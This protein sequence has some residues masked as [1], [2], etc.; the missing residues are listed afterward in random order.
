M[1]Q[2]LPICFQ[3]Y[4]YRHALQISLWEN[5]CPFFAQCKV[6]ETIIT[7]AHCMVADQVTQLSDIP[8]I[9]ST[10]DYVLVTTVLIAAKI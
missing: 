7:W 5:Q 10:P 1:R 6:T 3:R 9:P 2:S 8:R 4:V